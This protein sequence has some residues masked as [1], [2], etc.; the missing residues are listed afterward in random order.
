MAPGILNDSNDTHNEPLD[1]KD[2][3]RRPLKLSGALD[4]FDYEDVTP[5]I[6]RE[7]AG[8]N[9]VNDIL[10]NEDALRDLAITSTFQP[11]FIATSL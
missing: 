11:R 7:F 6:G 10:G 9:I 2:G 8:V 3:Y 5:V 4:A 1:G